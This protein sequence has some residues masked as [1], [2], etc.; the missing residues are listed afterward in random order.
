MGRLQHEQSYSRGETQE[1][2][3]I[4]RGE[5]EIFLLAIREKKKNKGGGRDKRVSEKDFPTGD[6]VGLCAGHFD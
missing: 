3:I 6:G 1:T 4:H 5:E 2:K